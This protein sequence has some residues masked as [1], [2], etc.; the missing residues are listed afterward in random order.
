[1]DFG[2]LLV[3]IFRKFL[4]LA[5]D[6]LVLR[7]KSYTT[8]ISASAL[9]VDMPQEMLN[10]AKWYLLQAERHVAAGDVAIFVLWRE[11]RATTVFAVAA[12]ESLLNKLAHEHLKRNSNLDPVTRDYLMEQQSQM[13]DGK[14]ISRRRLLS[15]DEKLSGWT[16][17]I[18]GN[19]FDKS[20]KVWQRFQEVK[21]FRDGL[22]HYKQATTRMVYARGTIEMARQAVESA[23]AIIQRFYSC[24]GRP[25]PP[26]VTAPYREVR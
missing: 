26:W 21:D 17:V 5:S 24:W 14:L 15:L 10:D 7:K 13:E 18:T 2:V 19:A 1:M 6:F 25:L 20:D 16:K 12:V 22:M 4:K 11:V 23:Q 8:S 9:I 3:R